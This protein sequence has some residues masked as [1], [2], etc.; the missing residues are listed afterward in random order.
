MDLL[1]CGEVLVHGIR[2]RVIGTFYEHA[3]LDVTDV[4][5][6]RAGDEVVVIGEQAGSK[7]T[8]EEVARNQRIKVPGGVGSVGGLGAVVREGVSRVYLQASPLRLDQRVVAER[9]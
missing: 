2:V 1:T 3:R 4:P 6:A 9:L 8:L 7:I 5:E